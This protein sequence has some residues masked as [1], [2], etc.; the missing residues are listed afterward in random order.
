MRNI[1]HIDNQTT[2]FGTRVARALIPTFCIASF[3]ASFYSS[4]TSALTYQQKETV[5]FTFNSTI[6]LTVSGDLNI[7]ELTP[8]DSSDSN[9]IDI[10]VATNNVL[11]YTLSATAGNISNA[12]TDLKRSDNVNNKFT[13]LATND[14]Y[15]SF[16]DDNIAPNTWGY[17]YSSNSGSTWSNY[18][19]L[20]LYTSTNG[21][22]LVYTNTNTDNPSIKFKIA[23]KASNTQVSGAY[24]NTINFT[25]LANPIPPKT[26]QDVDTWKSELANIGDEVQAIDIRDGNTYWV[27]RLCTNYENGICTDSQIWMTQNL[28]LCIGC[29]DTSTLDSTNTDLNTSGSGAYTNGYTVSGSVI[30]WT[31]SSTTVTGTPATITNYASGSPENSVSG[32]T[33]TAVAPQMAEGSTEYVVQGTPYANK[34]ACMENNS[35]EAC[36]HSHVGN[37]Y[38]WTAAI[39]SNASGSITERYATADNSICPRGWRLPKGPDGTNGSEFET[40][41]KAAGIANPDRT[42]NGSG[43]AVNVGY[44]GDGNLSSTDM[45]KSLYYFARSGAVSGT[46]LDTFT[47]YGRYWSGSVVSSN[48]AFNLYYGSSDLY[49]ANQSY[50]GYG[51]NLRCLAR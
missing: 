20:P 3:L 13:S 21:K 14:S 4:T 28:D 6:S 23:A 41:L 2:P 22:E 32:W 19:G 31:P 1:K 35:E 27:A 34:A 29:T 33:N 50:R 49:P 39:A 10:N 38:N 15:T 8:G 37:Y 36:E 47:S 26:M 17:S 7:E 5:Q 48:L 46:T 25:A 51:W 30:T 40:M 11:G 24:T 9:I 44:T 42:D 18:S 45:E 12:S 16:D 43:D